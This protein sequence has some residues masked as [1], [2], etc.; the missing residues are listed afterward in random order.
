MAT[1]IKT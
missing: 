1:D